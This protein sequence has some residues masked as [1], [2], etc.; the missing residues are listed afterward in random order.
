[1]V[2]SSVFVSCAAFPLSVSV[3]TLE[4]SQYSNVSALAAGAPRATAVKA[5]E[6]RRP[7]R[8]FIDFP[9]RARAFTQ[10]SARGARQDNAT[11]LAAPSRRR[12]A[13]TLT[14]TMTDIGR[15]KADHLALCAEDD[16]GFRG[17]STL[18]ECVRLVHD[19]LP[20]MKLA[21]VDTSVTLFGKRLR[22]P[23]VIAAM[24]FVVALIFLPET[25]D[26]DITKM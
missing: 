2:S 14:P 6:E 16:V 8:T 5:S 20:D 21:D 19:A 24:S 3:L 10:K 22:A 7:C 23:I 11:I 18:L 4:K 17:A 15:R 25:K 13:G 26:V 9:L 1:M 12:Y